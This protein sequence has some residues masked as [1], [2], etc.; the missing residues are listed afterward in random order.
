MYKNLGG[1]PMKY[2]D[3]NVLNKLIDEYFDKEVGPLNNSLYNKN[4]ISYQYT[5]KKLTT[6]N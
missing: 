1:R 3:I 5:K 2:K 6:T 4:P